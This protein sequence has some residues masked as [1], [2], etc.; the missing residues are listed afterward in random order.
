MSAPLP[1]ARRDTIRR[2][3]IAWY[4]RARRDLPWRRE[5][6]RLYGPGIYDMKGGVYL[7]LHAF[8]TV[9][10]SGKAQ[11]PLTYLVTPDE[12]IGS[13]GSTAGFRAFASSLTFST[14]TPWTDRVSG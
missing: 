11:L 9:A 7:A 14:S 10:G 13:P 8:L 3:L 6:D 5:G 1:R 4:R 12:E 2:R